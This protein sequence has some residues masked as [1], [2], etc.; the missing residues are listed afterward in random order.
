MRLDKTEILRITDNY[1]KS[2]YILLAQRF[3]SGETVKI[4]AE[5]DNKIYSALK[6]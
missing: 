1:N 5:E 6:N 2:S 3:R 4:D